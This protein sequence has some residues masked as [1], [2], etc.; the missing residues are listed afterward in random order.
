MG[1]TVVS[2][3]T[4]YM[5]REGQTTNFLFINLGGE[6]TKGLQLK[7]EDGWGFRKILFINNKVRLY[8]GEIA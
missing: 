6:G 4:V 2:D 5:S 3:I 7:I 1:M 8:G